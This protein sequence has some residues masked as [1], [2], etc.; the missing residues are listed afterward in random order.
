[1]LPCF[2]DEPLTAEEIQF[3]RENKDRLLELLELDPS[4]FFD[5][6]SA[7]NVV[8]AFIAHAQKTCHM[9]SKYIRYHFCVYFQ[10]QIV[11]NTDYKYCTHIYLY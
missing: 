5:T 6:T 10:Y 1:M 3:L 11:K 8:S 7:N 4:L 9:L 2:Q